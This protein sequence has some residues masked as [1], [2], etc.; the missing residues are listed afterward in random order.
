MV[1]SLSP[2]TRQQVEAASSYVH[3]QV[4]AAALTGDP[5]RLVELR[6]DAVRLLLAGRSVMLR[7][8]PPGAA[9]VEVA[10]AAAIARG[11]ASL[12]ADIVRQAAPRRVGI[13]G[14]DTSSHTALAL[15]LWGLAYRATLAPGVTL[16]TTRSDIA[17]LDRVELM[18]KGG[19]MGPPDLFER[20][21][22]GG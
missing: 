14:G 15:G 16:C 10:A 5:A 6:N 7:T 3:I 13:A 9:R 19:Q 8:A 1:G 20:L 2:V 11:A 21:L 22:H 18:L 17:A 4:D 12:A